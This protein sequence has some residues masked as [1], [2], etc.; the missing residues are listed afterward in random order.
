MPE[1]GHTTSEH[2]FEAQ[3]RM[4]GSYSYLTVLK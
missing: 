1:I 2:G 3:A 4:A